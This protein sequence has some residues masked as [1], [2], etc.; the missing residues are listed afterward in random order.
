MKSA[1]QDSAPTGAGIALIWAMD[2][3]GLIGNNNKMPWRLP[4]EMAYFR[5]TTMGH[6]VIMGRLTYESIGNPLVGRT[7]VV[8]TRNSNF[9]SE[10]CT[11]VHSIE[12]VLEKY[13][14]QQIFVIGGAQIYRQFLPYANRLYVT[15]IDHAFAGDEYFPAVDW[16]QWRLVSEEAGP[17]DERNPYP[18]FF[19]RYELI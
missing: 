15:K 16:S 7:N 9:V 5:Q 14:G 12:D 3:N 13:T 2:R 17:M 19:Q 10:G 8:L 11:V 18:Y 4:G 1:T 6:P